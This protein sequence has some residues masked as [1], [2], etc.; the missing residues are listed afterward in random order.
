MNTWGEGEA[1]SLIDLYKFD[2]VSPHNNFNR[3]PPCHVMEL[4]KNE[5]FSSCETDSW[6]GG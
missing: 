1:R 2:A 6:S 3:N 5:I 4:I